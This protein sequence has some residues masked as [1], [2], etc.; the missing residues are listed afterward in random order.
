MK[1]DLDGLM[2]EHGL[3]AFLVLGGVYNNPIMY[4]LTNGA[5][6]TSAE[7]VKRRGEPAV[8]ICGDMERDEAAKSG[9][10]TVSRG[11]YDL[12]GILEQEGD[13]L[14]AVVRYYAKVLVDLVGLR[15]NVA[16]YG[17]A[18][19]GQTLA[20]LGELRR[21]LPGIEFVGEFDNSIFDRAM[22]TKDAT[23]I[24]RIR[25]VAHLTSE[26]VAET[27]DF[28]CRHQVR[29]QTLVHRDGQPLTI[30]DVK[31]EIRRLIAER[32]LE[33]PEEVIFAIGRDAGVPHT[34]GADGDPLVLGRTI[35]YDIFPREVGGGYFF[36]MT[37]TF[38]LGFAEPEVEAVYADVRGC[39]ETVTAAMQPNGLCRDY[40][41]LACDYFEARGHPTIR[42][43]RQTQSGYVHSLGHGLGLQL[44]ARPTFSH[45]DSNPDRIVPGSVFTVEPGLYY[46]ERGFGVRIEDVLWLDEAGQFHNLT[47]Y[48]RELVIELQ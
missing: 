8:L 19:L 24:E 4:Y 45:L 48:P 39:L 18:D 46:P 28:L 25:H 42:S 43:D 1:S 10:T 11:H 2:A 14:R 9:L 35:V 34:H 33:D 30:G 22:L 26:I 44:H 15:G 5:K 29:E 6:L 36:D 21:L 7:V 32:G 40:Q 31:R 41:N 38:C 20:I 3:D 17:N 16:V 27:A 37:R 23:E 47:E 12:L 13:R